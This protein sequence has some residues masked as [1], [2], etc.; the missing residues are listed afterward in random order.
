MRIELLF[1]N[2]LISLKYLFYECQ[3]RDYT[4]MVKLMKEMLGGRQTLHSHEW[5]PQM[6]ELWGHCS[7]YDQGCPIWGCE[8]YNTGGKPGIRARTQVLVLDLLAKDTQSKGTMREIQLG[9][10]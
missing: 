1:Y 3:S 8:G 5:G 10:S 2:M 9:I 7:R 4:D 6:T